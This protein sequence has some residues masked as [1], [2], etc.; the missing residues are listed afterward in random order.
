MARA[1][2]KKI[3]FLGTP[4][5][6][7]IVLEK[8]AKTEFKPVL[9]ITELDKP[10]GR[11]QTLTPPPVK[12][13]AKKYKIPISQPSKIADSELQIANCKPDLIIVAAYGQIIPKGILEIPEFG[14]LNVHPSLL[15]NY[16]GPSPIQAAILNGDE[17]TGATI[18]LLDE[19]MDHG[20]ILAQ[21]ELKILNPKHQIPNKSQIPM[22]KITYPELSEKLAELGADLLINTIPKWINGEIKPLPQDD[23]KATFTRI[24]KKGDG[25]ID[26]TKSGQEIERQIRAFYPWP[27]S[28]T[29]FEKNSKKVMLKI[30]KAKVAEKQDLKAGEVFVAERLMG[31]KCGKGALILEIVQ[32]EGKK[33]MS[34]K[35]FLQGNKN[36]IG[37]TL[38]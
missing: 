12:V 11:K 31:V 29:F 8:L 30:I 19:K 14:C 26:W 20:P 13:L 28:F 15:P 21:R 7:A 22:T 34:S 38:K 25:K 9:V 36:I 1:L 6:G 37:Q 18:I 35:D 4:E 33:P 16:R 32:A 2:C 27:G 17:K 23:L 24:I 3:V 10:A 5:F